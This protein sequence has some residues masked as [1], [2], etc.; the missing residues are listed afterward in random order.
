MYASRIYRHPAGAFQLGA[1]GRAIVAA[2]AKRRSWNIHPRPAAG[3]CR[4]GVALAEGR[5][6]QGYSKKGTVQELQSW[7]FHD[8][9]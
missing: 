3:E 5:G 7:K 2:E 6:C 8:V 4:D 1:G 9:S